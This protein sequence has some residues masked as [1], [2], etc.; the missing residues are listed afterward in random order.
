MGSAYPGLR[1]LVPASMLIPVGGGPRR[2]CKLRRAQRALRQAAALVSPSWRPQLA[3]ECSGVA[4]TLE[5]QVVADME[6]RGS[7]A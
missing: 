1:L 7:S 3:T 2:R 6:E 5:L 4:T